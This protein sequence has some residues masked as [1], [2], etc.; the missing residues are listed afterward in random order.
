[1]QKIK[2]II[3]YIINSLL[4]IAIFLLALKL[5]DNYP[6]GEFTIGKSDALV[7]FK[8]MLYN[9][10]TKIKTN[11]L[12]IFS[13]N[14]GLGNP[15]AFNFLYYLSS[16]LNLISIFF[17][18]ANAM[19]L[20]TIIIK[21]FFTSIIMTFYTKKKLKNNILTTIVVL[22]YTFSSWFISYYYY[23]PW[24]D[25]FMIFPLFNYGIEKILNHEKSTI[26][27]LTLAYSILTNFYLSFAIGIYTIIYFIVYM[28]YNKINTKDII[29]IFCKLILSSLLSLLLISPFIYSLYTS[30]I[31]MGLS[32]SQTISNNYSISSSN[33]IKA[34][35]YGNISFITEKS[36]STFPNIA[37]N[38]FA[39]LNIIYYFINSKIRKKEKILSL[40]IIIICLLPIIIK[41]LDFIINFFHNINGLTFRYSFIFIF[42][43]ITLLIRNFQSISLKE[44]NKYHIIS[45]ILLIIMIIIAKNI[46]YK[47]LILNITF[48]LSFN[49]LIFFFDNNKIHHLLFILLIAIESIISTGLNITSELTI[50]DENI[51][52]TFYKETTSYRLNKVSTNN[53]EYLNYNMYTNQNATYLLTSMTYNKIIQLVGNLGC[54]TFENTIAL[55][56]E[57]NQLFNTLFNIKSNDYYLEKIY[58]V[59]KEILNIDLDP[60]NAK[61]SYENLINAMTGIK[62]IFNKETLKSIEKNNKYYFQTTNQFYFID[63]NY[64]NYPQLY[65]EFYIEKNDNTPKEI[66]IYTYNQNKLNMI[67]EYLK[68][69]QI[70]YTKYSNSYIEG[71]I[72]V[73]NNQIIFTS[74]PY[75]TSW[76]VKIDNK[77]V[78][79]TEILN[80][81]LGIEC[82]EGNHKISL[83]YKKDTLI[84]YIISILSL[85]ILTLYNKNKKDIT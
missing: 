23:L 20:S 64:T 12:E 16:P 28:I 50:K 46:N 37:L 7:Q 65:Q 15:T 85:I 60:Y 45:L 67:Y 49:V 53:I 59:N 63:N 27:I 6:F 52:S 84:P 54:S 8:P 25:I 42:L 41:P 48:L 79:T 22:S 5:C 10:I 36:G 75:D 77:K 74:I 1:M 80:G 69:N 18:T 81:L 13:F 72:N 35:F 57:E 9:Y 44:K 55:C 71:T 2:K 39:L 33:I 62:D 3:P 73:D 26:Y 76:E 14:N 83:E 40:I 51:P 17:K 34:F 82:P 66:T 38:T 11:T 43:E 31:K 30:Y 32:F 29:N 47:I 4:C 19:Y 56:P 70:K 78:K 61:N 68:E 58:S 24:L 21:L